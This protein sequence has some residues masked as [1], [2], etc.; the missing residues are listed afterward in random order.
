MIE[1]DTRYNGQYID[2]IAVQCTLPNNF[3]MCMAFDN[4]LC[5][6]GCGTCT[7]GNAQQ[8]LQPD[9]VEQVNIMLH[10]QRAKFLAWITGSEYV[11]TNAESAQ[12]ASQKI[13]AKA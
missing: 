13:T 12:W 9:A 2:I 7:P 1:N 6:S 8:L 5:F 3:Q 11:G 4:G 10:R